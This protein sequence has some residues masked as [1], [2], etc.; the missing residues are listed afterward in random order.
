MPKK[1][2]FCAKSVYTNYMPISECSSCGG[3]LATEYATM[4]ADITRE[5]SGSARAVSNQSA[6]AAREIDIAQLETIGTV[7]DSY[8]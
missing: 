1:F 3:N 7:V 4:M 8:A 6:P 2:A 5:A